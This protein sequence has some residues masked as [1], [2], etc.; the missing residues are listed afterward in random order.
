[1]TASEAIPD[2]AVTTTR[3]VTDAATPWFDELDFDQPM[4]AAGL[5]RGRRW[6]RWLLLPLVAIVIVA[7]ALWFLNPFASAATALVTAPATSGT[8]VSSVSLSGSVASSAIKELTFGTSGTVT[9]VNV[10][11]GDKVT[12]GEVLA[13]IDDATLNVQ[14]QTAQAN[15]DAANAKLALDQAGPNAATKA[16]AQDSVNQARLQ[17]STARQSL[18]DTIL[19]NNQSINQ[20]STDL[21]T[22]KST[23]ASDKATL[24]ANDPQLAKDQ[25]AV[26]QANAA[27]SSARL[28]ATLSL[29][30][31]KNQVSS[32]SLGLTAAEHGYTLKVAPATSAQIASDRAA[33]SSAK[34]ALAN[35]QVNGATITSPIDGT[36]TAVAIVVGQSVSSQSTSSSTSTTGQIEVMNLASLRIAGESS[37]T[38]IAKLKMDQSATITA[39]ALGSETVVGKVCA[40]SVVGTQISG[41][42]TYGVTVCISGTNPSLLVGMSATAAVVTNRADNAVLVPSLA[43]RTVGGQQVVSV[44]GSDGKTQ[45]NVPVTVGLTN[46]TQTQILTGLPSGAT[47]VES[48]QA[49]TTNRAGGGAGGGRIFQGGGFGGG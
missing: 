3:D 47:V 9:A 23:L 7:A 18:S 46:G 37:E 31:A 16:S 5:H 24:P 22:A 1:M 15:L 43:V 2:T 12:K 48:L 40:L 8:I 49:T 14:V 4:A 27:L 36:V 32:A 26:T 21:R 28:K 42:T 33:V 38:D 35:L 19:Q 30:Q 29:H 11:P 13:T 41:V 25:A 6:R 45:T 17:L 39:T 44:L 20:A 34:L 10:A